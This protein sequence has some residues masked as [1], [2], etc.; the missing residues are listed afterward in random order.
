MRTFSL[1]PF[2]G[3]SASP[4]LPFAQPSVVQTDNVRAELVSEVA[5]VKPGEPFWVGLRQTIRPKW[6][7]YWKNPGEFGP[8]DRD[9][10]DPAG[11]RQGRPDRLA[12]ADALRYRRHHQLRLQ[13]RVAAAGA[14]HAAGRSRRDR[15]SSRPT[16][17][18]WSARTSASPKRA[19][20][21]STCRRGAAATPAHARRRAPCSSKARRAVPT[22]SP[23]PA[24]Y[25]L[26]KSGDPTLLVEAK[27]LKP[28]DDQRRLFLP[29]RMGPRRHAWPSRTPASRPRASASR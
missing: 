19:S 25:G 3:R 22:Q 5:T 26:A 14:H 18:G 24:R 28:D 2:A 6:H 13:G 4:A 9:R 1:C 15:S 27:G 11:R 23:W 21:S 20:S 12:G 7:T 8:A 10:V 29:G 17:T 16:P